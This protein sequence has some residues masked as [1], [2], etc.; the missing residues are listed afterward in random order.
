MNKKGFTLIE[1]LAV[2]VI[3]GLIAVITVTAV[4]T[5][6]KSYR[7]SLYEKQLKSIESAARLWLGDHMLVRPNS[8]TSENTC[9]YGESCPEEY[10]KL[11]I[12]LQDLQDGGYIEKNLKNVKTKRLYGNVNITITKNGNKED[13][14]VIDKDFYVYNVGDEVRIQVNNQNVLNFYIIA[15]SSKNSSSVR[16][17][18]KTS[19]GDYAW[20]ENC[21]NNNASTTIDTALSNLQWTNVDAIRLIRTE[22]VTA[23]LTAM[24]NEAASKK[25]WIYGPYW[26][27]TSYGTTFAYYVDGNGSVN[28]YTGMSDLKPVRP[29]IKISKSFIKSVVTN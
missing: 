6:L 13:I 28:N 7:E 24:E 21:T 29:V 20:C 14:E 9:V 4:S 18:A 15:D 22:E 23:A 27:A 3:L 11:V 12:S 5:T 10:S 25:T 26:T 19:I 1:L 2:L 17:I 8:N 16:A